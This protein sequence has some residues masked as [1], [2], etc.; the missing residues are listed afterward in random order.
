M[1]P[2]LLGCAAAQS[3]SPP[4]CESEPAPAASS[5]PPEELDPELAPEPPPLSSAEGDG[6]SFVPPFWPWCSRSSDGVGLSEIFA[7]GTDLPSRGAGRP[8]SLP[9]IAYAP[10]VRATATRSP[11]SPYPTTIRTRFTTMAD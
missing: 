9:A 8:I 3:S 4:R 10:S 1:T 7:T 6:L 2:S 5:D 11:A